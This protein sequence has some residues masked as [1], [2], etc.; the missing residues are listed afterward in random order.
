VPMY[1]HMPLEAVDEISDRIV[2]HF[3]QVSRL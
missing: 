3:R 1:S 2:M